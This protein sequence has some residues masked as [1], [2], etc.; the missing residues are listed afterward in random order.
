MRQ[1]RA[2]A[3]CGSDWDSGRRRG[4]EPGPACGRPGR[5]R[6][7]AASG[8]QGAGAGLSQDFAVEASVGAVAVAVCSRLKDSALQA[9]Q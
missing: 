4:A 6:L 1:A 3:P 2:P 9:T 5:R 7:A 8:T